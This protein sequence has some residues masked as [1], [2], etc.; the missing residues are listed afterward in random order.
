MEPKIPSS[1]TIPLMSASSCLQR[2]PTSSRDDPHNR[3]KLAS[4]ASY[5]S[6]GPLPYDNEPYHGVAHQRVLFLSLIFKSLG[7]H[8]Y[9]LP[10]LLKEYKQRE[11][12]EHKGKVNGL[13]RE[14]Q[15]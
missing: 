5:Y 13:V 10:L 6:S 14:H 12:K 11:V 4:T 7:N 9:T 2:I 1:L 3:I 15:N 8:I